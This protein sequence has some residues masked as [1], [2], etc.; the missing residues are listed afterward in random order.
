MAAKPSD[1]TRDYFVIT[2]AYG[3]IPTLW[4]WEI[5]RRSKPLGVKL[6][7]QGFRSEQAAKLAGE[8]ALMKLLDDIF[9]EQ[10]RD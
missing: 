7:E 1:L 5:Q 10:L 6:G 2:K 9:R 3:R 8:R 4:G